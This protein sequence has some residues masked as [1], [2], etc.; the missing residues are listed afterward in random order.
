[1]MIPKIVTLLDILPGD[2]L[3][4]GGGKEIVVDQV[5][6][7][8]T[9]TYR[10]W[11]AHPTHPNH[12]EIRTYNLISP[13]HG[14]LISFDQDARNGKFRYALNVG[15]NGIEYPENYEGS[16]IVKV[17]LSSADRGF[18]RLNCPI[19]TPGGL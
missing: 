2:T 5:K 10:P 18:D 15:R 9:Y 4:L 14:H 7:D 19:V 6:S 1:M 12:H 17:A 3:C 11:E 13:V 8:P 16:H